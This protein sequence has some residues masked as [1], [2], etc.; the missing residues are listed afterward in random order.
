MFTVHPKDAI[1]DCQNDRS[2]HHVVILSKGQIVGYFTLQFQGGP[3]TYGYDSD[4]RV[5]VRALS[6]DERYRRQGFSSHA[7]T[8]K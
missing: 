7:M 1:K 4:K 3:E 8:Y 5:L 6:I 2:R